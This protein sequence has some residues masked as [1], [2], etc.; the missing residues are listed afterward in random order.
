MAGHT[1]GACQKSKSVGNCSDLALETGFLSCRPRSWRHERPLRRR[2][3]C[4]HEK[5]PVSVRLPEQLQSVVWWIG[6]VQN[7]LNRR[8][9]GSRRIL[10]AKLICRQELG[11]ASTGR[12]RRPKSG[13]STH[14]EHTH[15]ISMRW[16]DNDVGGHHDAQDAH[17]TAICT[18]RQAAGASSCPLLYLRQMLDAVLE[19]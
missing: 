18:L 3:P 19:V 7:G 13:V 17:Y 16:D 4:P 10:R 8:D 9:F 1:E 14:F 11:M 5:N 15:S 6:C 12:L 2:K